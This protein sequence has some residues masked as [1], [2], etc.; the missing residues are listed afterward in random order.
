[1]LTTDLQQEKK[2]KK[3][4]ILTSNSKEYTELREEKKKNV[5]LQTHLE[6]KEKMNEE[7]QCKLS[8]AKD[9]YDTL[10]AQS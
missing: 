8:D 10:L 2:E 3:K 9:K 4:A 7:E 5:R 1:M 6:K